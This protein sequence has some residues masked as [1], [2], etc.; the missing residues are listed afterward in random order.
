MFNPILLV[1]ITLQKA[2]ILL[3]KF[4][5]ERENLRE[6]LKGNGKNNNRLKAITIVEVTL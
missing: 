4:N 1:K 5:D 3:N 2:N 6:L